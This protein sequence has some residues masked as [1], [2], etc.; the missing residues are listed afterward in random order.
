LAD[1]YLLANFSELSDPVAL[2]TANIS[3]ESRRK[4]AMTQTTIGQGQSVTVPKTVNTITL[5][6]NNVK[7]SHV[8]ITGGGFDS[9]VTLPGGGSKHFDT[10]KN[11]PT[12]TNKSNMNIIVEWP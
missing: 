9:Q 7:D 5:I 6:N 2:V 8:E 4:T 1:W 3:L 11:G 12:V 10:H